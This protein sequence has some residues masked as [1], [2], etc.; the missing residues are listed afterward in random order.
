MKSIT[1]YQDFKAFLKDYYAE[2][3]RRFPNFNFQSFSKKA[4]I[5]SAN[6]LTGC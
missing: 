6:Y 4:G 2:E 1:A 3:K 5:K